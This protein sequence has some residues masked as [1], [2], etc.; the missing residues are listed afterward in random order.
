MLP[1]TIRELDVGKTAGAYDPC[2]KLVKVLAKL[3]F[4]QKSTWQIHA[5]FHSQ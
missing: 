5:T 4:L 1:R 3:K 2:I